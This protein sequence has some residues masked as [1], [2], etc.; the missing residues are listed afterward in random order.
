MKTFILVFSKYKNSIPDSYFLTFSFNI[1]FFYPFSVKYNVDAAHK[2]Y[3]NISIKKCNKEA[4]T[5][6]HMMYGQGDGDL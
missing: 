6:N 5:N 3:E 4:R 2:I 1:V